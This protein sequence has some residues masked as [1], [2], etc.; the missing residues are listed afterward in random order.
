MKEI[1]VEYREGIKVYVRRMP[2]SFLNETYR[3]A[4][5]YVCG[6]AAAPSVFIR[7]KTFWGRLVGV[8]SDW[9]NREN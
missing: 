9:I 2:P 7:V 4:Y 6:E 5:S 3:G 8:V 1:V